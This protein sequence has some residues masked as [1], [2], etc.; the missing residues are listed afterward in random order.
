MAE[1]Q[2]LTENLKAHRGPFVE[3]LLD[4]DRIVHINPLTF[5]RARLSIG[6]KDDQLYD[7]SW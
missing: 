6:P 1:F 7:D 4:D 3:G 5:G 2:L